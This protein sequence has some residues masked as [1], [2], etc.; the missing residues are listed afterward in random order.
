MLILKIVAA[1]LMASVCACT[2]TLSPPTQN[3]ATNADIF[4]TPTSIYHPLVDATGVM[5]GI[6]FESANDAAGRVFV[7]PDVAALN[8][9]FDLADNS[10]LCRQPVQ[11]GHFDL[12]DGRVLVGLWSRG[13]GCTAIHRVDNVIRDETAQT[14]AINLTLIVE[15]DCNY[16]LVRP[17]WVAVEGAAGYEVSVEVVLPA[18]G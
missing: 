12:S 6:C 4:P 13:I 14:L 1:V 5:N 7:L 3:P 8:E 11:R 10:R 17:F 9:F 2:M 16:E 18:S 15:G